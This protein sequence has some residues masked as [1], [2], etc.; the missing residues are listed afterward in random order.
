MPSGTGSLG[1]SNSQMR[2]SS[3]HGNSCRI[4]SLHAPITAWRSGSSSNYHGLIRSAQ[5]HIDAATGGS[6]IG[7]GIEEA[8]KLVEKMTSN[9]S[10]NEE[11]T[12]TRT[13]KV[14]QLEEVDMLTTKIHLLMKKL[15]NPSLDHLKR[16]D[17]RVTCEECGEIGHMGV[18]CPMVPQDVNF[19]GNPNNGFHPNQGLNAG[20]NK[21]SFAFDNR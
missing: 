18:N 6:F 7:L 11:C 16:V 9:Q 17:T 13:L 8:R 15:E 12:Q 2:P 10:W 14:Q 3:R 1:F 20:W 21:T 4:I 19:V 5:E